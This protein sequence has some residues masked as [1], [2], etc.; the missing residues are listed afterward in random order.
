MSR[1]SATL[2]AISFSKCIESSNQ[3]LTL[4]QLII[5]PLVRRAYMY[6]ESI[7][8]VAK[9]INP[10][11]IFI[12]K[13]AKSNSTDSLEKQAHLDRITSALEGADVPVE[14]VDGPFWPWWKPSMA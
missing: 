6:S 9:E 1:C 3:Y 12:N 10:T 7:A 5:P 4:T 2:E 11:R 8:K 13:W 14:T